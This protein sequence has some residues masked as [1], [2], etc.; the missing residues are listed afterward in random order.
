M[1]SLAASATASQPNSGSD[2]E[3]QSASGSSSLCEGVPGTHSLQMSAL[4]NRYATHALYLPNIYIEPSNTGNHEETKKM[5]CTIFPHWNDESQISVKQFTG[6]ITNMLLECTMYHQNTE[7]HEKVL[8]RTYGRGTGMI[9]DRDREFVSHL[10]IN[11]VN[12]APPI[13]ARFGNGLVYG[14]IEGRSL[15]FTELADERLYP[16][17]AAKLGQW[18]QQVQVDA[19]EEC[20]AKLRRE[21]RG[22]KPESNASDLWSVISNWI[23]LLPEIEGIISSCTQNIDIR[24]VQDPQASLVDVLRAELAWLRSQLNSKSPL[25]ASHCD[26]LSGNVI[27][28]EDLS[29]KL[30]TGLTASEMEYYM[31]HNP[32]S[33]IDYE[34]MVKAPR[35]FDIS[36]HFMEWQGFN[37][38]RHRIPKAETSNQRHFADRFRL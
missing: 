9:I 28:S 1:S 23:Q 22:S 20:L 2:M 19:I 26:L 14:F 11:S 16:L 38:E 17:I 12:L 30:E 33:F 8:V 5:L 10:V 29:Q 36:N 32:I 13:H 21:F 31:Q 15:E 37:C 18:H 25:V 6:G 24:E 35:A 27:I 4:L 3:S 34:Y 7:S